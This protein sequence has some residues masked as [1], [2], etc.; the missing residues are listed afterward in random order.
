MRLWYYIKIENGVK[1]VDQDQ[2]RD[3]L[4]NISKCLVTRE[5]AVRAG[6]RFEC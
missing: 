2:W 6:A 1:K 5:I 3:P 4:R